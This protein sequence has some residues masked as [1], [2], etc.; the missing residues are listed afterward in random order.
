MS[1]D[2]Y[3]REAERQASEMDNFNHQIKE[4]YHN[5]QLILGSFISEESLQG[6]AYD[7]AKITLK[8]ILE[9]LLKSII[10]L[11][12][13]TNKANQEYVERYK[14]EVAKES[15]KSSELEININ[16]LNSHLNELY[17]IENKLLMLNNSNYALQS[18]LDGMILSVKSQK[19]ILE[20][21]LERL[22]AFN[23]K[24]ASFLIKQ[25]RLNQL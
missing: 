15:L 14:V 2:M 20:D 12:E 5:L 11:S 8:D 10:V 16:R 22:I 4:S 21:K 25:N 6:M 9:P 1:I 17:E 13:L 23:S 7:S 24:S 18:S 19:R 3:L